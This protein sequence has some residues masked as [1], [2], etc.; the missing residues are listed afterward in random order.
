MRNTPYVRVTNVQ[1]FE[2]V[3]EKME[4]ETGFKWK[5]KSSIDNLFNIIGVHIKTKTLTLYNSLHPDNKH[6]N[7][8]S[9]HEYLTGAKETFTLSDLTD[10]MVIEYRDGDRRLFMQGSLIGIESYGDIEDYNE[11]L[12]T[13]MHEGLDIVKVY[14]INGFRKS[15]KDLFSDH[16]LTLIFNA[17]SHRRKFEIE[18]ELKK[19]HEELY[20]LEVGN[21]E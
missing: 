21:H 10:G 20:A 1:E 3:V 16:N 17:E 6:L 12:L 18:A 2:R 8:I 13:D 14:T 11:N 5:D 7:T 9:A 19:L 4:R 15:F